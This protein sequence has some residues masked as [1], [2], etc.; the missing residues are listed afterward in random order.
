[1][2]SN[3][4]KA[5]L[6][7]LD[8]T[9]YLGQNLIP[10]ADRV[11]NQLRNAGIKVA[12]LTNK[13]IASPQCYADKLSRLGIRADV[14]D[15]ITSVLLTSKYMETNYPDA[16]VYVIGE[17][18]LIDTLSNGGFRPSTRPEETD[19]VILSL[20]RSFDYAKLE[21]AYRAVKSGAHVV[22]TN[23]DAL[24]PLDDGEIIDAGA[25]IAA[26][27]RLIKRP[28][29]AVLGKPSFRCADLVLSALGFEPREVLMV[30]DRLETDIKMAQLSGMQSALVLSGVTAR[31]EAEA[32]CIQPDH[33]LDTVG[34]LLTIL[35]LR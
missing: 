18:Y 15:V 27:E 11:V 7:D 32:S 5:V 35:A 17:P 9:V 28:I 24:C 21:F 29:D 10:Q 33:I 2:T 30:G 31:S 25:W 22:A 19:V 1:M 14:N 26:L 13:P 12:F 34:E 6:L 4:I 23:P 8:G 3:D 16:R 20:D